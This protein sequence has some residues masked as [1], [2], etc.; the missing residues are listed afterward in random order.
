MVVKLQS[1][2]RRSIYAFCKRTVAFR[3]FHD[4]SPLACRREKL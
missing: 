3:Q 4:H 1:L 2:Y